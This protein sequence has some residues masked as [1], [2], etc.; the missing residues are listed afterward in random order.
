MR[1]NAPINLPQCPS[2]NSANVQ[3]EKLAIHTRVEAKP[4]HKAGY[5]TWSEP[6]LADAGQT[7][8]AY[9]NWT[10]PDGEQQLAQWWREKA[11]AEIDQT[12]AK[13][14]EYSATDLIDIGRSMARA[15]GRQ[16]DDAH[17]AE[18][19]IAFY[20]LG[21]VSRIMG[22]IERGELPNMDSWFDLGVY[23]R[24]AQRVRQ[25]GSW[26]GVDLSGDQPDE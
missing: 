7:A 4:V 18:L 10:P 9:F 26:P 20:A 17:A 3:C 21:K 25:F 5:V 22:A 19:A 15:A 6:P 16:V 8:E 12:V 24:M 1:K 23:A 2:R 11:E 13:A 14:V